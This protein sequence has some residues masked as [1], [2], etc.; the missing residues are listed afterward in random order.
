MNAQQALTR[1]QI[2]WRSLVD[3]VAWFVV[4]VIAAT[5]QSVALTKGF[6]I[7]LRQIDY[8]DWRVYLCEYLMPLVALPLLTGVLWLRGERWSDV[9]FRRPES[10]PRFWLLALGAT[11]AIFLVNLGVRALPSLWGGAWPPSDFAAI[12]GHPL[13]F[14]ILATYTVLL[15]G[16]TEEALFRGFL[17]SRVAR[18]LGD[19]RRAWWLGIVIVAVLFGLVHGKHGFVSILNATAIGIVLGAIYLRTGR[20]LWV[21]VAAHSIYDTIRLAQIYYG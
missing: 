21:L 2:V 13:A 5:A 18:A 17:L 8:S 14:A 20:N 19:T 4:L 9:G 16:I 10:W 1:R 11:V 6:G 3:M 12:A 15:V 7:D